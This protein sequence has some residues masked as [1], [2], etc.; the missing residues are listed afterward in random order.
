M[1]LNSGSSTSCMEVL[2]SSLFRDLLLTSS[3]KSG[4]DL[5]GYLSLFTSLGR[6]WGRENTITTLMTISTSVI[7]LKVKT[8]QRVKQEEK[9]SIFK[10]N[11]V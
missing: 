5:H 6:A 9:A 11:Y 8:H 1:L 3:S 7:D 10:F 2:T 4:S